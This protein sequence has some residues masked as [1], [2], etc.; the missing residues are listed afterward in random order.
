MIH[1]GSA[2]RKVDD[3]LEGA[4]EKVGES[5]S[6]SKVPVYSLPGNFDWPICTDPTIGWN[7]WR[8]HLGSF[9]TMHWDTTT[10]YVVRRQTNRSENFSFLYKRVLFIGLHMVKNADD[11]SETTTRLEDNLQWVEDNVESNFNNVDVI[12]IIGYSRFTT[13]ENM[14]FYNAMLA[15]KQNEWAEKYFVY[16]RR[17]ATSGVSK[18]MQGLE[19]FD[20]LRVGAEWPILDVQVST[21]AKIESVKFREVKDEAV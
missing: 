15:K 7:Q 17:A 20:E 1:L 13:P 12:F 3:C 6:V 16:A 14:P 4:Y 10:E 9:N 5:L 8:Q 19:G 18:S 2:A 11:E 21:G